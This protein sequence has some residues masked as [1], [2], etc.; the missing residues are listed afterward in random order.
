MEI[1]VKFF[2]QSHYKMEKILA[3]IAWWE[4]NLIIQQQYCSVQL[5]S[6]TEKTT[7]SAWLENRVSL[8]EERATSYKKSYLAGIFLDANLLD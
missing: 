7:L 8:K 6:I 3:I 4:N 1:S 2:N 5:E